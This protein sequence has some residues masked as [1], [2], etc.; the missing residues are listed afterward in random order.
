MRAAGGSHN[1]GEIS[2][3]DVAHHAGVSIGT[4]SNALNRPDRVSA[5]TRAR[6]RAVIDEL[7]YVR[8]ESA[9]QLRSGDSRIMAL[10]VLDIGNPFFVDV[11]RGA[12]HTARA[13]GLGVMMCHSA[14]DPEAESLYLSMFAEQRVRG[15]LVTPADTSGASLAGF[16]RHGIPYVFV[17]RVVDSDDA[18]SV[19]VDDV[20]GGRF[21]VQHLAEGGHE[22]IAYVSG[23][24]HLAQCQDRG[25]GAAAAIE[26]AGLPSEALTV[27]ETQRLD[28]SSGKDAG[29][30][31]LGLRPRPTA[32]FCANDLLALGVLQA[33]FA[34]GVRVPEDIALVGYDDIE[35][36]EAAAVPLTSVRQPAVRIGETAAEMLLNETEDGPDHVHDSVV[37]Q[38]ELIVRR[39]TLT[40]RS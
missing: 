13:R 8:S 7:G 9:R 16:R 1:T 23:P 6:V 22:R 17:D 26:E 39:S 5:D 2:I 25:V 19:S 15:V 32:V 27:L 10:L 40:Q 29:A 3:K 11:S 20:S 31:L 35:F 33:M 37:Y 14:Q 34:A 30:R 24:A 12:E 36:A 28:V 21:A 18:C 4:V 38:P